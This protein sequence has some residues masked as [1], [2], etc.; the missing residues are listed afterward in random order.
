MLR[1]NADMIHLAS[2]L[3]GE[4]GAREVVFHIACDMG[5]ITTSDLVGTNTQRKARTLGGE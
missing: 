5:I 4:D 1:H 3:Y 2:E